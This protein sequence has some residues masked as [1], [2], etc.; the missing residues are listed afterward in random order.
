MLKIEERP[1][2]HMSFLPQEV[3]QWDVLKVFREN[4]LIDDDIHGEK[5]N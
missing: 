1:M 3:V 5:C 4:T 2:G